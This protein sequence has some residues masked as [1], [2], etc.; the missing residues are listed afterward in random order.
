MSAHLAIPATTA[1]LRAII[2]ARLAAVYGP[3]SHPPVSVA[4]PP[5]PA[6]DAAAQPAPPP[7]P[8]ALHLFMH[9]AG[10]N[11]TWR[12]TLP[13]SPDA[14]GRRVAPSPVALD[15]HYLLA[16]TGADLER[17]VLLGVG[18]AALH[19]NARVPR[20]MIA[21]LF[22]AIPVP[23]QPSGLLDLL[24]TAA[25]ADPAHQPEQIAI[26]LGSADAALS[27]KLW[28]AMQSPLRPCAH[29]LVT[30]VFLHADSA[31]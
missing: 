3:R 21:A 15:L 10:P 6:A 11:P 28:S 25:L 14:T 24:P 29:Y 16:A 12:N 27:A 1:V 22:G 7:E 17:E 4:P 19:R 2:E 30:T 8:T 26:S 31:V 5:R 20:A 23:A 13:S 9:A 18:M